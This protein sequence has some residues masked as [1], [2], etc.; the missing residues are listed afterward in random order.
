MTYSTLPGA[1]AGFVSIRRAPFRAAARVIAAVGKKPFASCLLLL[2]FTPGHG[3]AQVLAPP[4]DVGPGILAVDG[5]GPYPPSCPKAGTT[6]QRGALPA[7]EYL[8]A[9]ANEPALCLVRIAGSALAMFY[10]I[11]AEAWPG[12][13]E[14][15]EALKNVIH[16]KTG[17]SVTFDTYM[18]PTAQ[19]HDVLRNDGLERLNVFG[20][21]R[22]ALKISHYREGF[23]GNTYRSVTTGWKDMQT[24]AMIYVTYRHISGRPEAG[25]AW[26][27][28]GLIE[29]R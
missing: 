16:G 25:T 3:I 1:T 2:C 19:W 26:D 11:W 27:A 17:S 29:G 12:S 13:A 7:I 14:A 21:I 6:V 5:T 9:S 28:T 4:I 20:Q 8:G 24:G 22:P 23:G 10:G 15:R 18:G